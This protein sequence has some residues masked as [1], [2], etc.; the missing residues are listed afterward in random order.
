[1]S[2][3]RFTL[4][5]A[6]MQ[7]WG[8]KEDIGLLMERLLDGPDPLTED[9]IANA[10]LGIETLHDMRCQRLFEIFARLLKQG[11][12]NENP[13][14]FTDPFAQSVFRSQASG[15]GRRDDEENDQRGAQGG[16]EFS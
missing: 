6:I 16:Q 9:Q 12:F 11:A 1:M 14:A 4:E 10:L 2:D 15:A 13:Q 8:T 3:N 5:D 7:A